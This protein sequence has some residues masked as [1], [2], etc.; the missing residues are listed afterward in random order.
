MKNL[1]ASPPFNLAG[2]L[3]FGIALLVL[4]I[5]IQAFCAPARGQRPNILIIL[6][7]DMGYSDLGCFGGEIDTPNIDSLA[8]N[9][10]RFTQFYNTAR[11]CPTRASLLT[12][13]YPHETGMGHMMFDR[14]LPGYRGDL[15]NECV[16]IA[17]VLRES[18]YRTYAIGKWHLTRFDRPDSSNHNW[19]LQRG[20]EK[21][22]GLIWGYS[23]L[24]DPAIC[25]GNEWYSC[26]S[27]PEYKAD[28]FY[29]TDAL[30]DNAVAFLKQHGKESPD[31]PFFRYTAYTAA[32]WPMHALERDVAKYKGRF[33]AG[34]DKLREERVKRLRE[35]GLLKAEWDVTPTV[36]NWDKVKNREWELRCMEVYAA[37]IDSMDQGIGRIV[38]E[39]KRQG[40]LD[41]TLI[42]FLQDNGACA[43]LRGRQPSHGP[44]PSTLRPL[45][46][47]E[48]P[49]G[50]IPNQTRDGRPIKTGPVVMPGGP[51]SYIAYGLDWANVSN[52]PFREYK[53]WVHEG[54]IATPLIVHWPEV[55]PADRRN[56]LVEDP[57]HLV[58][59]MATC[60]EVAQTSYPAERKGQSVR[61]VRGISLRP[62]VE[63]R[64]LERTEPLFFEHEG[65]RAVRD[66]KWKLVAKENAPWELYDMEADRTEMHDLAKARPE[67]VKQLSN[68]WD[69]WAERSNVL[70]LGGWKA[71]PAP[72]PVSA[73]QPLSVRLRGGDSLSPERSPAVADRALTVTASIVEPKGSGVLVAHG[74]DLHGYA[75][76]VK[77][78]RLHFAVR[79]EG[80]LK[81]AVA[82]TAMPDVAT[83]VAAVVD[84][85]GRAQLWVND[86]EA[87]DLVDV[88][89][90]AQQPIRGVSG[91]QDSGTPVGDYRSPFKYEGKLGELLIDAAPQ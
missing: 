20:F 91:G 63:G 30:S 14:N 80:Q 24:Y 70:P 51:D 34:Y 16:T 21:Y 23:S 33:D 44:D 79:R 71:R 18:G 64:K 76:Y 53:H 81:T 62:A 9:G 67:L 46:P 78:G 8:S 85:S 43:E 37:M 31:K 68:E 40:Q 19:P 28:Q 90:L 82:R 87:S 59:I 49:S 38:A 13:L 25:R 41:N 12:G 58:D 89:K 39:L 55:I 7:D 5:T 86:R 36:G 11:C 54:G 61:P 10:L 72:A 1:G 52:T 45:H 42:M 27:D 48:L 69:A 29:F 17:E 74:A 50:T 56:S 4:A 47:E 2:V 73:N 6:S 35:K 32:H 15:N 66:G 65:N 3:R 83:T 75:L 88:G 77:D 84:S 22:Y 57:G 60:I 26:E